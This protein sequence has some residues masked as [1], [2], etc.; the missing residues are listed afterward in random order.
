MKHRAQA[1]RGVAGKIACGRSEMSEI[2]KCNEPINL[3]QQIKVQ[4]I[5]QSRGQNS[6]CTQN[7]RWHCIPD[8]EEGTV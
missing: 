1:E 8:K 5:C 4:L 2:E 7:R 6:Q 3:L